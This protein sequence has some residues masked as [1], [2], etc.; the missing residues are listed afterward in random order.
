MPFIFVLAR[1]ASRKTVKLHSDA[2]LYGIL[3]YTVTI[4]ETIAERGQRE[5]NQS[6][7]LRFNLDFDIIQNLLSLFLENYL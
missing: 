2:M 3:Y 6:I 1:N 7:S 4:R 5:R